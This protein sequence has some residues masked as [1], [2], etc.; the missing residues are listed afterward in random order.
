MSAV[1]KPAIITGDYD[2]RQAAANKMK[3]VCYYEQHMNSYD[4]SAPLYGLVEVAHNASARSKSWAAD[5]AVRWQGLTALPTRVRQLR[6]GERG[7]FNIKLTAMP[8]CLGEPGPIN[9]PEFDRWMES[10][11]NR[12]ALARAV[13]D[14]I[15]AAFPAGGTVALS[16]GHLGKTSNPRDTGAGDSDPAGS[17]N[18]QTE[19][20]FNATVINLVAEHLNAASA[21]PSPVPATAPAPLYSPSLMPLVRIGS[22]GGAV[23]ILQ[24]RL[25]AHGAS[26]ALK[27]DG[28]YGPRTLASVKAFQKRKRLTVDGIV[29]PRTWKA[30]L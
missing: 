25:N 28:V 18:D 30:L 12:Y 27:A 29:G 16:V 24:Q 8:A 15:M 26:P 20:W 6:D 9:H 4:P 17:P 11:E 22:T 13:A 14:S 1:W 23:T 21:P 3:A 10:A 5:L 19:A 2:E 7:N